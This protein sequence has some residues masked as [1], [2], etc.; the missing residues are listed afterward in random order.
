MAALGVARL[1]ASFFRIFRD[2]GQE[3]LFESG[4]CSRMSK[5]KQPDGPK[6]MH[7][8]EVVTNRNGKRYRTVLVRHSYRENGKVRHETIANI[9]KLPDD[10]IEAIRKRLKDGQPFVHADEFTI[11]R[12]L[13]H[14]HVAAVLGTM[15]QLE[16]DRLLNVRKSRERDLVMAMIADRIL[17]PGSKLSCSN[18]LCS[19][20]RQDTL[21]E[22]LQ[23]GDVDVHELYD[24][25]DWLLKAQDRIERKLAKQHLEDGTLV[26]FDVSSS[27]YEGRESE[28]R[29]HGY[30]RDHRGDRP[31]V[32]YG[33]LCDREGRPIAVKVFP[34]NTADPTT[35]TDLVADVQQR[36]GI[37]QLIFVGDRGMIT[38][39][40]IRE[41]LAEIKGFDWVSALRT[42]A[43]RKLA[44][45]GHITRSL[46]DETDLVEISDEENFPGERL[47][48]C[49]NPMLADER[50]RK[51]QTLLK[52]T[53]AELDKVVRATQRKKNALKGKDEIG[54]RVGR[55]IGRFKMKKHF[56]LTIE[57]DH[58]SY[59]RDDAAIRA[60]ASLDGVYVVRSSVE[61]DRM[62]S[63][64]LVS[65]Y[66]G[67]ARVERAFRCLKT[68][69]LRI[70]PI[71]HHNDDRIRAH[72]F[73]CMLAYY[74][75]WHMRDR[76]RP[77]MFA[78]TDAADADSQ[79]S[80]VVGKAQRSSTAK[81]KERTLRTATDEPVQNFRDILATLA[82]LTRNR[83]RCDSSECE[84]D[85]L[86]EA[87]PMQRR[88][89]D[90]LNATA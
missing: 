12:S 33:L 54:L 15:K 14:G 30:S 22:E 2:L 23:L 47:V 3:F 79:R 77:V 45:A 62:T 72:I 82:T 46:F 60:E 52:A 80:S 78:E 73:L 64:E 37:R 29:R 55:V 58:F 35:F 39:A 61:T 24:A 1:F 81:S 88:Y 9:S 7:V 44:D 19:E 28:L 59:E 86:S 84:Y 27:Y 17:S 32:V 90:L 57:D 41:D 89:L 87:T 70:R 4:T 6:A 51:R 49:R 16:I 53:E 36:F 34:G 74:V 76:L 18:G 11:A 75:E 43:I 71:Y 50:D 21:A 31:Q 40:R 67:L 68:V 38:S 69:D 83:I 65:T 13:P 5:R 8:A 26:L 63:D 85:Q 20:T 25:L 42:E 66:K 56:R 10:V 48:V